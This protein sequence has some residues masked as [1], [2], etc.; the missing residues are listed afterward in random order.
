M[1]ATGT[2]AAAS[3]GPSEPPSEIPCSGLSGVPTRSSTRPSQP[4]RSCASSAPTSQKWRE[5]KCDWSGLS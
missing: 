1:A 5:T 3:D 2:R 4:E